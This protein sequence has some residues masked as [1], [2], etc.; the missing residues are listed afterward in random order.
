MVDG[1]LV[2]LPDSRNPCSA[3]HP[4][5]VDIIVPIIPSPHIPHPPR[6]FT[7]HSPNT[8]HVLQLAG[9]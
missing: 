3:E 4:M 2:Q 5:R 1:V 9:F 6:P 8:P 7:S